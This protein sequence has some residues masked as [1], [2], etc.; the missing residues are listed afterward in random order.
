MEEIILNNKEAY[1]KSS[2]NF[3]KGDELSF[4]ALCKQVLPGL[5]SENNKKVNVFNFDLLLR[6][7][8]GNTKPDLLAFSDD[9]NYFA[10]IEVETSNHQIEGHV[11]KQMRK[12][13]SAVLE[14]ENRNIFKNL[15]ANNNDFGNFNL[16]QFS[17]MIKF[18]TPDYIVVVDN[19]VEHWQERLSSLNVQLISISPYRDNLSKEIYHIKRLKK[20]KNVFYIDVTWHFSYFIIIDNSKKNFLNNANLNIQV[21]DD[22]Y[23]NFK[24]FEEN[25]IL[26]LHPYNNKRSLKSFNPIQ[27]NTLE[28]IDSEYR[29]INR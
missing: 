4:Q 6:S 17:N 15:R 3:F 10:I 13:T 2:S 7:G 5:L 18:I 12:I 26:S 21:C 28:I 22:E 8:W 20:P 25:G 24:I 27:F 9:Y 16:K 11:M 23:F 1:Q 29:L 19:Y 14:Y